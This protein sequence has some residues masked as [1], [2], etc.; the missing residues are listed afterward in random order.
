MLIDFGVPRNWL[1]ELSFRVLV[2]IVFAS[3]TNEYASLSFY[4]TDR[5]RRFKRLSIRRAD[6]RQG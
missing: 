6:A 2:P 5:S 4:R 1:T 3:V